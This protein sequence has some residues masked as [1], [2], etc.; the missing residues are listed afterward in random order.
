MQV[1]R[2]IFV[3]LLTFCATLAWDYREG[4]A[5]WKDGTCSQDLQS[6]LNIDVSQDVGGADSEA[7][8]LHYP[9]VNAWETGVKVVNTGSHIQVVGGNEMGVLYHR[10]RPYYV[11]EVTFRAPA[12]HQIRGETFPLEMQIVHQKDG[13]PGDEDLIVISALYRMAPQSDAKSSRFLDQV[14]FWDRLPTSRGKRTLLHGQFQLGSALSGLHVGHYS[15]AGST[16]EP[17]CSPGVLWHV[18]E[19]VQEVSAGQV[20][21][22]NELFK[23][24][25]SF[26]QGHGNNRVVQPRQDRRITLHNHK[27]LGDNDGRPIP[28]SL[29][30]PEAGPRTFYDTLGPAPEDLPVIDFTAPNPKKHPK[31]PEEYQ[32][33]GSD[34]VGLCRTGRMQSPIDIKLVRGNPHGDFEMEVRYAAVNATSIKNNGLAL[35]VDGNFGALSIKGESGSYNAVKLIFQAPSEHTIDGRRSAM[36][37]Q[38]IHKKQVQ[39]EEEQIAI[40]SVLFHKSTRRVSRFLNSLSWRRLPPFKNSL[41]TLPNLLN[42]NLLKGLQ[43]GY[44]S[45]AGSLSRPPC[46]EGVKRFVMRTYN[47]V[48]TWQLQQFRDL[49]VKNVRRIQHHRGRGINVQ[50]VNPAQEILPLFIA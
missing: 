44:Y 12:E 24:N 47:S 16:T 15:Y 14:L 23:G 42:L 20:L 7:L 26:A 40:V 28:L 39:G 21:R 36:E 49:F 30:P 50:K 5:N 19:T 10:Q 33:G 45:Y 3:L 9:V 18:L 41:V 34:W 2:I 4:G 6:P 29:P 31:Q 22:I 13:S 43:D 46:T 37:L 27:P 38:I 8:L 32:W 48:S 17:P 35:E 25:F 1:I 11:R